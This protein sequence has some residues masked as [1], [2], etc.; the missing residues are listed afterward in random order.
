MRKKL[1]IYGAVA[2]GVLLLALVADMVFAEK[3]GLAE[4]VVQQEVVLDEATLQ[5]ALANSASCSGFRITEVKPVGDGKVLA[6]IAGMRG[7]CCIN[8]AKTALGQVRGVE[9]VEIELLRNWKL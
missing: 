9:R 5:T 4:I 2:A 6:K 8:P 3:V 7:G 1:L